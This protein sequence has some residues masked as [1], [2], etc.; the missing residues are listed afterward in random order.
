[1]FRKLFIYAVFLVCATPLFAMDNGNKGSS[2]VDKATKTDKI[3]WDAWYTITVGKSIHSSYYQERVEL[4]KGRLYFQVNIWKQEEGFINEEQLGVFSENDADL[5][6]LFYNFHRTF[7]ATEMSI[8]GTIQNAPKSARFLIAKVKKGAGVVTG[9]VDQQP[10][11][12]RP[13][14]QHAF[15]AQVFPAWLGKKLSTMKP[16]QSVSFSSI[17]EDKPESDACISYG[18]VMLEDQIKKPDAFAEKTKTK[19]LSVY[20]KDLKS[21]WWINEHGTVVRIEMPATQTL[22][23]KVTKEEAQGFLGQ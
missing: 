12:K 2:A 23:Q 17:E 6:P 8:D 20:Y 16:G 21:F 9:G 14:P 19:K 13:L 15:F 22:V 3:L 10:I 7:G 4:K 1:M 18:R 11:I 5:T